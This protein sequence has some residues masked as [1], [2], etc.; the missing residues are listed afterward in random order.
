[1]TRQ[2]FYEHIAAQTGEDVDTI[3]SFGFELE[4]PRYADNRRL[5]R[6]QRRWRPWLHYNSIAIHSRQQEQHNVYTDRN[7]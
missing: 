3:A 6:R 2:Q 1:M 7:F 5:R 4:M